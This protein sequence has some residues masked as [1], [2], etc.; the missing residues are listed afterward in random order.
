[1]LNFG[2]NLGSGTTRTLPSWWQIDT[3]SANDIVDVWDFGWSG[4]TT[5]TMP[6]G[7]EH[8]VTFTNRTG[9]PSYRLNDGIYVG[10]AGAIHIPTTG[11]DWNEV[12]VIIE[13]SNCI[14]EGT[15]DAI[16]SHYLPSGYFVLQNDFPDGEL[17]WTCG[18]PDTSSTIEIANSLT[19]T[20][21]V[22]VSG[23]NVYK[24]GA[25]IGEI[26]GT[27]SAIV[28]T[29]FIIGCITTDG[30]N[31][32]Q[33]MR[34]TIRKVLIVKRRLTDAEHSE[35]YANI[36]G[37]AVTLNGDTVTYNGEVITHG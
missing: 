8:Q 13:L 24:N 9:N 26:A 15:L 14:Q 17:R 23:P 5:N 2:F 35:I 16:F 29:N 32:T 21:I 31:N 25:K 10:G 12:S 28:D 34:G 11:L 30:N 27:T 18:H 3:L 4:H 22:G 33:F 19:P 1:M 37:N 36:T 7:F 20:G 6:I